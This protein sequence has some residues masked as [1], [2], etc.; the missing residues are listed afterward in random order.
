METLIKHSIKGYLYENNLTNDPDDYVARVSSERT[1]N[2]G[3]ICLSA[4]VRGGADISADTMKRGVDLFLKEMAYQL[5]DGYSV[6]TGY[7]TA[8][9]QIKG[10]FNSPNESFDRD[11]HNI[12]FMFNQGDVLRKELE[13]IDVDIMG[14]ADTGCEI[15]KVTDVK[16]GSVNNLITPN[17]NLRIKGNKV[18]LDGTD[19]QV[20]V[21]FIKI[22]DKTRIK[23]DPSDIVNNNPSELL[24][25]VPALESAEYKLEVVTQFSGSVLLKEPRKDV[26]EKI[27]TVE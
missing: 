21:Y 5:C 9:V 6:N 4:E 20:G 16:S 10:V 27:L 15:Q 26:F 7:F 3:D 2:T 18:K 12:Y 1:L 13:D 23:V 19:E 11:K 8:G 24:I 17:R 25:V 22:A 14:V